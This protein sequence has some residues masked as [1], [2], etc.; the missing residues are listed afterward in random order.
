MKIPASLTS[1]GGIC[2]AGGSNLDV[3]ELEMPT[4][5]AVTGLF[6]AVRNL[7]GDQDLE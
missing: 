7:S 4:T 3:E 6:D 1:L 2:P 5:C